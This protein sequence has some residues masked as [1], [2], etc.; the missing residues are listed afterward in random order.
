M[1]RGDG[2]LKFALCGNFDPANRLE[3]ECNVMS[4]DSQQHLVLFLS[5][6]FRYIFPIEIALE[7]SHVYGLGSQYWRVRNKLDLSWFFEEIPLT[8]I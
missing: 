4:H 8:R 6:T 3:S 2:A 1:S 5:C 7:W